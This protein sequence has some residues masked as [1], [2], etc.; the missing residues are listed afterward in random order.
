MP[1]DIP[2]IT[3]LPFAQDTVHASY[4]PRWATRYF[5][6]L[7]RIESVFQ[8]YR[9]GFI[10]KST[11]PH[12]FWHHFDLAVTRFSGRPAPVREG[13]GVVERE[14]YSHEVISVGFWAGDKDV[15]EPAFY[16]YAY[17]VPD[18][19]YDEPLQPSE[20]FWN[21]EAGMALYRYDD[22]RTQPDA[23]EALLAFLESVYLAG[24]KRAGWDIERFDLARQTA[25]EEPVGA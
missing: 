21:R 6:I 15:R 9:S 13:A 4:D 22:M 2:G 24:A 10:G 14:A 25:A 11:P 18:G 12:V 17:P 16:G 19:L 8:E 1:Y 23:R 5:R 20:A 3:E 7:S